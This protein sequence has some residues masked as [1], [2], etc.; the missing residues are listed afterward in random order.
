[1]SKSSAIHLSHVIRISIKLVPLTTLNHKKD[2]P[3]Y[4]LK[5]IRIIISSILISQHS[6]KKHVSPSKLGLVQTTDEK[7]VPDCYNIL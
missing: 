3:D 5:I 2:C 6:K 7:D 4:P 1:M